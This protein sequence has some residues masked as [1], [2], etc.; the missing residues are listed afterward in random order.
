M[1][2]Y[3]AP[4]EVEMLSQLVFFIWSLRLLSLYCVP[5]NLERI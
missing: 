5:V 1:Y 2:C 3:L 4:S